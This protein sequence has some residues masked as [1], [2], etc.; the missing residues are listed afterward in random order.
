MPLLKYQIS[1]ICS[2]LVSKMCVHSYS[3]EMFTKVY[4]ETVNLSPQSNFSVQDGLK[5]DEFGTIFLSAVSAIISLQLGNQT[6]C[7][8]DVGLNP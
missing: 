7:L 5:S 4:E 3:L 6:E 8:T 1:R 2:N